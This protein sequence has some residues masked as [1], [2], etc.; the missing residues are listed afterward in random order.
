M[1]EYELASSEP[2]SDSQ[3]QNNDPVL[4]KKCHPILSS[5]ETLPNETTSNTTGRKTYSKSKFFSRH[6]HMMRPTTLTVRSM[7]LC[8]CGIVVT[9]CYCACGYVCVRV[10]VWKNFTLWFMTTPQN[11]FCRRQLCSISLECLFSSL[12]G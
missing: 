8:R 4:L 12:A 11:K 1:P 6:I 5:N 9:V 10:R 7:G 2:P 3:N